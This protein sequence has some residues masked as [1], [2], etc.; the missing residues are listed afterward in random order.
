MWKGKLSSITSIAAQTILLLTFLT[1]LKTQLA[2]AVAGE[3]DAAFLPVAP[4]DILSKFVGDSEKA[5][6]DIFVEAHDRSLMKE[7][8]CAVVFFDE[9]DA[10]GQARSGDPSGEGGRCSRGILA[11]LLVQLNHISDQRGASSHQDND[12]NQH[13]NGMEPERGLVLV[14]AATNRP[15]DC[16]PALLRRFGIRIHV[17]FPSVRDCKKMLTRHLAKV[18]NTLSRENLSELAEWLNTNKWSGSEIES[19]AR[20]S[21]MAPIRECIRCA[22]SLRKRCRRQQQSG[23]NASG[24]KDECKPA[25]PHAAAKDCLLR[26][27]Q[28]LRPVTLRDFDQAIRFILNE[29][30]R[31]EC[32]LGGYAVCQDNHYDSSSEEDE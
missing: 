31:P 7:S 8:R 27:L 28:E 20:E 17:G 14:V 25:D 30:S 11:E 21:A 22:A 29:Q 18:Q 32:V 15:E 10:L 3:A 1:P 9:I 24:Q 23:G 16:D 12:N 19:V 5:V 6:N 2:R 4:S 13:H 26:Q